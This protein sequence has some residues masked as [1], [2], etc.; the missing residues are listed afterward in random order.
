MIVQGAGSI[1]DGFSGPYGKWLLKG[2]LYIG[3]VIRSLWQVIVQ[4]AG[5][6]LDGLSGPYER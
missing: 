4:G 5:S 3:W 2:W 1:L 6:I